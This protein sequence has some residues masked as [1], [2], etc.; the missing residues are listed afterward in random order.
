M[1][2]A[3]GEAVVLVHGLWLSGWTLAPLGGRLRDCGFQ[4][5]R[6]SYPSVRADLRENAARLRRFSDAVPGRIVHFVGHS[7]GGIVI[8]AM[9]AYCPPARA[10]RVVTLSSPH[11][12]SQS[13]QALSRFGW[14]RR[15]LGAGIAE[16]L[17]APP[18]A[19]PAA[20][21]IGLIKGTRSIGL[22]RLVASLDQPN[23]GVVAVAEMALPGAGDEI[24][25]P[26][27]HMGMLLSRA[28]AAQ[29]CAFLRDGRF[30]S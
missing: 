25:L 24:A 7:L 30:R 11:R 10:G 14:G 6:F 17:R 28:V 4:P 22:G 9:L 2:G 18:P 5:H 12:G 26:V 15:I 3:G 13:A 8:Q 19:E 29:V 20:R 1:R 23:D 16:L 27:S 21:A